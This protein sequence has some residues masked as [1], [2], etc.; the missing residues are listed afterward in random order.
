[1]MYGSFDR[2]SE[3]GS[4]DRFADCAMATPLETFTGENLRT[5]GP[6]TVT[7]PSAA[8]YFSVLYGI[9]DCVDDDRY[10]QLDLK[11]GA[12]QIGFDFG[13]TS[14]GRASGVRWASLDSQWSSCFDTATF[15]AY[16]GG[17]LLLESVAYDLPVPC[18]DDMPNFPEFAPGSCPASQMGLPTDPGRCSRRIFYPEPSDADAPDADNCPLGVRVRPV[19]SG[20]RSGSAFPLGFTTVV[21]RATDGDHQSTDCQFFFQVVDAEPPRFTS[22]PSDVSVPTDTAFSCTAAYSYSVT[23]ADNCP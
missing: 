17:E 3:G 20:T 7:L 8:N 16:L 4:C 12:T 22:C 1:M 18:C 15:S 6:V 2:Y 21:W 14:S 19:F 10:L 23:A 13:Q 11:A 9:V 5:T